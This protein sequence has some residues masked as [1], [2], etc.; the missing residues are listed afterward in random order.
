M[1]YRVS[2]LIRRNRLAVVA[3]GLAFV[4]MLAGGAVS[5][6]QADAARAERDRPEGEREKS[7]Q[8]TEFFRSVFLT[9]SPLKMGREVTVVEAIDA[10]TLRIDSAFAGPGGLRLRTALQST[11][12]TTLYEMG[13]PAKALPLAE[14]ALRA[15][16]VLDSGRTTAEG[17][18]QTYDLAGVE[19]GLGH[20]ARA[21]SLFRRSMA[22]YEAL[23]SVDPADLAKGWGQ[24]A[25]LAASQGR[26][27]EALEIQKRTIDLLRVRVPGTDRGLRVA[28]TNYGADLTEIGRLAEGERYL[29]EAAR[30]VE[31][32]LGPDHE[33][34]A[35]VLH[36]LATN[37]M[38]A[39]HL[40]PAES[41]ARRAYGIMGRSR[42]PDNT[43]TLAMLRALLNVLVERNR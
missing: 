3:A 12:A 33:D 31:T 5:L 41:L 7:D 16:I 26:H 32:N 6:W 2:R 25:M 22:M 14:S 24:V 15:Q 23:P 40:E 39:S 18:N 30:L 29:R 17:A 19:F 20:L 34:M 9:A 42:G 37:L 4:A 11:L 38:Y 36:P 35:G 8:V 21:E 43:A 10:A 28:L 13:L 27:A 1:G